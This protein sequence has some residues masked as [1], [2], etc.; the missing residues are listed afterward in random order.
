MASLKGHDVKETLIESILR[1]HQK[2][3]KAKNFIDSI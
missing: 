1:K 3:E 2:E